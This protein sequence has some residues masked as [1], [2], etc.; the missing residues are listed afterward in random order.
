MIIRQEKESDKNK[1]Y[2]VIKS[3]FENEEISDHDEHNLVNRLRTSD[4]FVPE[5]S[6]VAEHDGDIV[7]HILFTEIKVGDS[8]LLT[9]APVSVSPS[10]QGKKIGTKLIEEGHKVAKAKG[11]KGCVVLGH[12]KYYPKFGYQV[13]SKFNIEAP[14]EVPDKN[15]MAIELLEGRLQGI[16]GVV[17]YAKEFFE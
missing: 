3:A 15:F 8:V 5:L 2:D 12:D 7:G 13:A 14:F 4:N 9:L 6:I 1:V 11:Y 17:E 10:M 16:S